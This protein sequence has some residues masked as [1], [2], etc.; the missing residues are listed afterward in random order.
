[1]SK[2]IQLTK[3]KVAIVDDE[4]Y[5]WLSQWKWEISS[6]GYAYRTQRKNNHKITILMHRLIV[7]TPIGIETDHINRDKL[8]N[9]RINLRTATNSQNHANRLAQCNNSLGL[10]GICLD[11]WGK[12]YQVQISH[13][14]KRYYLGVF[15]TP[16]EALKVYSQKAQELF[17]EYALCV[18]AT[19]RSE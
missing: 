13:L 10:R 9:R 7:N 4:D 5:E 8:D 17:G 3:G 16:E 19:E 11:R 15:D 2:E 12:R 1:M 18:G 14:K 6:R